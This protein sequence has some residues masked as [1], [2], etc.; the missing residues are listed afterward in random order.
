MEDLAVRAQSFNPIFWRDRSVF[1]TGHTGFKGSWLSLWLT[2]LGARVHGYSLAPHTSPS[3]FDLARIEEGLKSHVV[4]DVRDFNA[5]KCAILSASPEI[6]F[7]LAAQALVRPSYID[8][9]G[10]YATNVMGTANVLEAIRGVESVKAV[11]IVTTD[12]CYEN[13]EW[14]WGYRE[15]DSL[16]GYDPYSSSKACAELI[17]NAY[18]SSFYQT[19]RS[20]FDVPLIASS[21]AGNVIGGGDWSSDR[22]L[23]DFYRSV[24]NDQ[25]VLIR[26]P[27]AFRPWQH[28]LDPLNGYLLLAQNLVQGG[29]QFAGAFNFGPTDADCR[30]VGQVMDLACSRWGSP[31]NWHPDQREHAHEAQ[32]LRLDTSK[33]RQL[34]RWGPKLRV[35]AAIAWTVDW[36]RAHIKLNA[37]RDLCLKQIAEFCLLS[38]EDAGHVA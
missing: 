23:P 38:E 13:R 2:E 3:L 19:T 30:S 20:S 37:S 25:S 14:F 6:V 12:K 15:S 7:H 17:T 31:A 8:P 33:A 29:A 22:L 1:V 28:V 5:L 18:R 16:G 35:D 32:L 36:Y 24:V 9:L 11:V 34:L 4:S 26:Y 21:R 10:T 27:N